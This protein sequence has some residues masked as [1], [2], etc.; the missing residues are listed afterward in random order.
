MIPYGR[1]EILEEDIA[2]VVRVLRADFITQGAEIPAFEKAVADFCGAAH[3]VAT[4]SATSALHLACLALELGPGDVLWTSPVTFVASANCGLHCG[5][6][7]D[8]VDIDQATG[9]ISPTALEAKLKDAATRGRLPK[10]L[11][12]VHYAGLSAPMRE[13]SA[14]CRQYGVRII[15][16]AAHAIGGTYEGEP[17]G[18]CCY[19][20][21]AVFSFHPVKVITSAE[22]GM[23]LTND[24]ALAEAMREL[25]SHGITRDP[26]R[27]QYDNAPWYYEQ[28]RLGFNYRMPDVLAALGHSQ[29]RR[30]DNYV[31]RRH[32]LA[33]RYDE[34]LAEMPLRLPIYETPTARS[35]LHLYV[36]QLDEK[37]VGRARRH[38]F[39]ALRTSGIGVQ[40]HYIPVHLQ[41]Y[42]R[43]MGFI[44][45]NFPASESFYARALTIPLF[46][47][48]SVTEQDEVV[49]AI[50]RSLL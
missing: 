44:P 31:N 13:I 12:A 15:E 7:V 29:F 6:E 27:L 4:N 21:I 10:V 1:Q 35:A 20:D 43:K 28:Q 39:E 48:L 30:L 46:P 32:E 23:A 45:G 25:R 17:V 2:A 40:V 38:V 9:N 5:A 14:L 36:V 41:P 24:T 18:S 37:K 16:D 22:G 11:V 34:L 42:Y 50:R 47:A 26:A 19:S 33:R 49:A 3:A 8:F